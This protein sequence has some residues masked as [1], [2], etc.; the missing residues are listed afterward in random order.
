MNC[1]SGYNADFYAFQECDTS[2]YQRELTLVLNE[3]GFDG[4]MKV[5]SESVR[6]GEAIFYRRDRF[7]LIDTHDVTLKDYLHQ[8]EHLQELR[9]RFERLPT[10]LN[11][12]LERNTA[13]QVRFSFFDLIRSEFE[14]CLKIVALR[15]NIKPNDVFLICNTHL[16][17]HHSADVLRCLQGIV[18]CER[19]K[20]IKQFYEK[21]VN[22]IRKEKRKYFCCF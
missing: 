10:V 3:F 5:K 11:E 21:E 8:S 22:W 12:L 6:E 17:F 15:S 14:I 20:E 9:T 4:E 13:L 2:F 19:I 16:Y 18:A 7:S 1:S